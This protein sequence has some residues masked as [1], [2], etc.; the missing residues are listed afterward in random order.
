MPGLAARAALPSGDVCAIWLDFRALPGAGEV[1]AHPDHG[2]RSDEHHDPDAAPPRARCR[3]PPGGHEQIQ[4]VDAGQEPHLGPQQARRRSERE[5]REPL[6]VEVPVDG[7]ERQRDQQRLRVP[8]QAGD[9]E[10][11]AGAESDGGHD[12]RDGAAEARGD[13]VGQVDGGERGGAR[14][15][16]PDP[17]S[18]RPERGERRDQEDGQRLPRRPAERVEVEVRE[19]A[20]P[21]EP[22]PRVVPQAGR[23]NEAERAERQA[24]D[25]DEQAARQAWTR[26]HPG[27]GASARSRNATTSSSTSSWLVS[28]KISCCAPG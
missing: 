7:G 14:E 24:C 9:E 4:A 11:G 27:Y 23:S 1:Q 26:S 17:R 19:L 18:T 15:H 22:G 2:S 13:P 25:D 3:G 10:V 21:D 8:T 16:Q 6:P 28:L 12:P 20:P 5:R